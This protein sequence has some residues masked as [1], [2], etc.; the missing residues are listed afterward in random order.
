MSRSRKIF[1]KIYCTNSIN[2]VIIN[3]IKEIKPASGF[4]ENVFI[5]TV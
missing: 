3:T 2:Y 5:V 1:N 4:I